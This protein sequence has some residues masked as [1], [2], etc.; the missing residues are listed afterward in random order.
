MSE[1]VVVVGIPKKLI[2]T[3]ERDANEYSLAFGARP[4]TEVMYIPTSHNPPYYSKRHVDEIFREIIVKIDAKIEISKEYP[5]VLRMFYMPTSDS[6]ALKKEFYTIAMLEE[7]DRCIWNNR[8]LNT[9]ELA[10]GII[11]KVR[12]GH[13]MCRFGKRDFRALPLKNFYVNSGTPLAERFEECFL[14]GETSPEAL[15]KQLAK[16]QIASKKI[17]YQDHRG[18]VFA[19]CRP[20]EEH[21]SDQTT[22]VP[23][24]RLQALYRFGWL[25]GAGF[26]FDVSH[27]RTL[28]GLTFFSAQDGDVTASRSTEY[29]NIYLNDMVRG[30]GLNKKTT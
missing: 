13:G 7:L 9:A 16:V 6:W 15:D 12:K 25:F 18:C 28:H 24:L 29:V 2:P 11:D 19:P 14:R 4:E 21:G 17:V 3:V 10:K 23:K 22:S 26:H 27:A 8:K 30:N 20:T 5:A 1:L